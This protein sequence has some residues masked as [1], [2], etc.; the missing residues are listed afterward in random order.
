MRT[1]ESSHPRL[2][3]PF[4]PSNGR[5]SH[6]V[7]FGELPGAHHPVDGRPSQARA[8]LDFGACQQSIPRFRRHDT[9]PFR[10][11]SRVSLPLPRDSPSHRPGSLAP[12]ART[13]SG[14]SERVRTVQD[15]RSEVGSFSRMGTPSR[16]SDPGPVHCR[17]FSES[18][19]R[20]AR[21]V[22]CSRRSVAVARAGVNALAGRAVRRLVKDGRTDAPKPRWVPADPGAIRQLERVDRDLLT[23][24]DVERPFGGAGG[25]DCCGRSGRGSPATRGCCGGPTSCGRFGSS[26]GGRRFPD[27][28][29]AA[30]ASRVSRRA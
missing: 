23:R 9:K 25:A 27:R 24:R 21:C 17:V 30:V 3:L 8:P 14:R 2:D 26:G 1:R 4:R 12:A 16:H 10:S 11:L 18:S 20:R 7:R 29:A 15:E 22:R 13:R 6:P 28:G 5:P 19:G